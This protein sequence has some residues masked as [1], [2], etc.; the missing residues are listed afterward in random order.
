MQKELA[1]WRVIVMDLRSAHE[2]VVQFVNAGVA[3]FIL[4]D[5]TLEDFVETVRGDSGRAGA[6]D[7][8][9]RRVVLPDCALGVECGEAE[10]HEAVRMTQRE[11]GD[12]EHR[13]A[14]RADQWSTEV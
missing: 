5:A 14:I 12:R 9:D 8:L 2:E 6:A 7:P 1:D 3:V 10:A 13:Q 4:K 11:R